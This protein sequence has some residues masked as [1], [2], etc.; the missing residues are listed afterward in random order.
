MPYKKRDTKPDWDAI[1]TEYLT[2]RITLTALAQKHGVSRRAIEQH[3][4]AG[5]WVERRNNRAAKIS[6]NAIE[7][8]DKLAL[9]HKSTIYETAVKLA[10]QLQE[11]VDSGEVFKKVQR[12]RDVTGALKDI[13][14]VLHIKS[15]S[16]AREQ[17]A[18]INKLIADAKRG[19]EADSGREIVVRIEGGGDNVASYGE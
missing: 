17:E 15:E 5:K 19:E 12:P 3:S 1:K 4:S 10:K 9:D 18:R 14:D 8:A 7:E 11:F 6:K 13:S 2:T 16:D